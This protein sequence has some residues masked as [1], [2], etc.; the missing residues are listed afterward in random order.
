MYKDGI[1][2]EKCCSLSVILLLDCA[3]V[4]GGVDYE[5]LWSCTIPIGDVFKKKKKKL[6]DKNE[7][8]TQP[9]EPVCFVITKAHL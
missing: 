8:F 6:K 9:C 3:G 4:S 2:M 5:C 7:H 1:C